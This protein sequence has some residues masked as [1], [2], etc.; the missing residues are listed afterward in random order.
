MFK[1]KLSVLFAV[2]DA[3]NIEKYRFRYSDEKYQL[4]RNNINC[5]GQISDE[6][7]IDQTPQGRM[8]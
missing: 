3:I 7:D 5:L 2:V 8:L 1:P 4:F 6:M